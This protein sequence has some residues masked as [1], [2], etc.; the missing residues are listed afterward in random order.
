MI[1]S[2]V[3]E[4]F[5]S[6]IP[7][8]VAL[9]LNGATTRKNPIENKNAFLRIYFSNE[10]LLCFANEARFKLLPKIVP[11]KPG[12][13]GSTHGEIIDITPPKNAKKN[14]DSAKVLNSWKIVLAPVS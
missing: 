4:L 2:K 13:I 8:P 11:I 14:D 6:Q 9:K 1:I 10:S 5:L 3:C 12:I 7:R